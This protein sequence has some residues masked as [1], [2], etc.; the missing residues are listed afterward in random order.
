MSK[1]WRHFLS[2]GCSGRVQ[3]CLGLYG[4]GITLNGK[5]R[6][7]YDLEQ[8]RGLIVQLITPE[9]PAE[10]AGLFEGD[11]LLTLADHPALNLTG[12]H[13]LIIELPVGIPLRI[14]FL[15]GS[16]LL[17][18]WAILNDWAVPASRKP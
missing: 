10:Q 5:V 1:F 4:R 9:G 2:D 16:R 11:I 12:L 6:Q 7:H 18:R 3:R 13:D 15:R 14:T 17:E 8:N